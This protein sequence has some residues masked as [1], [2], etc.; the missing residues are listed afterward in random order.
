MNYIIRILIFLI[1]T[2]IFGTPQGSEILIYGSDTIFI[3][4]YPLE[5]LREENNLLDKKLEKLTPWT[6]SYC[7]RGYTGTWK[8]KNDSLFL[9]KLEVYGNEQEPDKIELNLLFE[10]TK[11]SNNGVFASWY[12]ERIKANYGNFLDYDEF[13]WSYIY[14]GRF[15]CSVTNGIVSD[16]EIKMKSQIEIDKI[17]KRRVAQEDTMVCLVVEEYPILLTDERKY[18]MIELEDYVKKQIIYPKYEK[19]CEGTV[20][21]SF[22]VEKDGSVSRKKYLRKLC[23]EQNKEAMRILDLMKKWEPGKVKNNVVRT[24][25]ILPIRYEHE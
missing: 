7:W 12:S 19:G 18:K 1:P 3:D 2:I 23:I 22:I 25:I 10:K 11:I 14:S 21:I 6:V 13:S 5:K 24:Q 16:I 9:V 8:I 20:F 15:T 17:I 4:Y